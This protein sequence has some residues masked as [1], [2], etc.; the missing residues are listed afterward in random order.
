MG[1][2]IGNGLKG[3]KQILEHREVG[4]H[5]LTMPPAANQVVHLEKGCVKNMSDPR[6]R[7]AMAL[8]GR[9]V[10]QVSRQMGDA[11]H[12]RRPARHPHHPPTR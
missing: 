6:Q 8:D 2:A 10:H 12:I 1:E 11:V 7:V 4:L 9:S 5:L 3:F